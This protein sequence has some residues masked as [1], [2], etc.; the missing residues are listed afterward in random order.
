ME[1]T[2][3]FIRLFFFGIVYAGP[4]LMLL[5]LLVIVLGQLIGKSEGW[6]R[7]D[8]LYYSF[9]T[10][11]TVGYGDFHPK[12]NAGKLV[13]IVIAFLGLLL[14]G[15]IVALGVKAGSVAFQDLYEISITKK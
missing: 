4:V 3:E 1:L 5:I 12:S 11:T 15:I 9:I 14:T 13:A 2:L 8:S 10:A 7:I 6:S